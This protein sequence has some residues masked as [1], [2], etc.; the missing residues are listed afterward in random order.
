MLDAE[1]EEDEK[2]EKEMMERVYGKQKK[3]KG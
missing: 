2:K 3:K 1:F